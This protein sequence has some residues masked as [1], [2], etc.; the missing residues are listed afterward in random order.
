MPQYSFQR[1]SDDEPIG[2]GECPNDSMALALLSKR[3][4]GAAFSLEGE[5]DPELVMIRSSDGWGRP[6]IPV[7]RKAQ[8]QP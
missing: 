7:Y 3:L 2:I 4:G 6:H 1:C 5:G 8:A